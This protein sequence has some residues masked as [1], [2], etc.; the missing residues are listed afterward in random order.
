MT[1]TEV[2]SMIK[3]AGLKC[4]EVAYAMNMQDSNFSR[5]LRKP[6]NENEVNNIKEIINKL[7]PKRRHNERINT[8]GRLRSFCRH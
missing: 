6:F 4:W 8:N 1:G 3:G 7:P 2:K 5:R